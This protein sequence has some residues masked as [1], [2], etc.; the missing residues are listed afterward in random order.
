MSFCL[1]S[2]NL[3]VKTHRTKILTV[4]F[5]GCETWYLTITEE[6]RLRLFENR[7]LRRIFGPK[8][9]MEE[10]AQCEPSYFYSSP[11]NITQNKS[12]RMRWAGHVA[13]TSEERK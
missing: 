3:N 10:V 7:F 4:V 13:S 12:G 9:I 1:L 2:R 8:R 11:N 5:Y 6:S